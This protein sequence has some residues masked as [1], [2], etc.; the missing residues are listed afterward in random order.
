MMC[1]PCN[2]E[3]KYC[4]Y[5]LCI[6]IGRLYYCVCRLCCITHYNNIG[7]VLCDD[8][9]NNSQCIHCGPSIECGPVYCTVHVAT[10]TEID[11]LKLLVA[12]NPNFTYFG[13]I[14][15]SRASHSK[16]Y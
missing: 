13:N 11:I 1:R 16:Y 5:R 9:S 3:M 12:N 4:L 15:I 8:N 2:V 10:E 7:C 6:I 14:F